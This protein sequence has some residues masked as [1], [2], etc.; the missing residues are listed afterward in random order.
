MASA[1]TMN[2]VSRAHLRP[3]SISTVAPEEGEQRDEAQG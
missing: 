3:N 1:A 2:T